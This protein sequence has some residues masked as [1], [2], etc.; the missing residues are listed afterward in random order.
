MEEKRVLNQILSTGSW[1]SGPEGSCGAALGSAAVLPGQGPS[2]LQCQPP[3][4]PPS[5]GLRTH[6]QEQTL[7]TTLRSEAFFGIS[8]YWAVVT[9]AD[10]VPS[11][12]LTVPFWRHSAEEWKGTRP[13]QGCDIPSADKQQRAHPASTWPLPLGPPP[14]GARQF[15]TTRLRQC[16]P[17]MRPTRGQP[18]L[19]A[20]S[21]VEGDKPGPSGIPTSLTVRRSLPCSGARAPAA[22]EMPPALESLNPSR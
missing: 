21:E 6:K 16:L 17:V 10:H 9:L 2:G 11:R 14:A 15:R 20:I 19:C 12:A 5:L 7:N 8:C 18:R 4:Q 3:G 22:A 13:Q 1:R